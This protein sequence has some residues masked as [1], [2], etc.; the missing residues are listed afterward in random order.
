MYILSKID[1]AYKTQVHDLKV[2]ND[3][4]KRLNDIFNQNLWSNLLI[5][6]E[7][8]LC[9]LKIAEGEFVMKFTNHFNDMLKKLRQMGSKIAEFRIVG[10]YTLGL[11]LVYPE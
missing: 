5:T 7:R 8:R 10:N 4:I 9:T 3:I 6:L 11:Q 2:P 1:D